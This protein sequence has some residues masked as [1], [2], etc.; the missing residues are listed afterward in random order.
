[1]VDQPGAVPKRPS[2][3][4]ELKWLFV[5]ALSRA[6]LDL[7]QLIAVRLAG[8]DAA[9]PLDAPPNRPFGS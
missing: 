7:V 8:P 4:D 3:K 2:I 5:A 1:M 6:L 9:P